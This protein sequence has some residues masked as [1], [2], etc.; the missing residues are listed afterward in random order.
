LLYVRGDVS[1]LSA[2]S[3]ASLARAAQQSMGAQLA[4]R[5]GRDLAKR[6]LVILGGLARGVDAL[7]ATSVGA[8]PLKCLA[9]ASM[10]A[11]PRK[12]RDCSKRPWKKMR[13]SGTSNPAPKNFPVW[14]RIIAGM[15][16]G[17]VIEGKQCNGSLITACLAMEFAREVSD[18]PGKVT[19]EV[20][21]APNLLNKPG[22]KLVQ[23]D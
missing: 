12:T 9:Q 21:F 8:A 18:V 23:R 20:S 5:L 2:P 16:L 17:V 4:E 6:G 10:F 13:S 11:I 19:E 15:P 3:Y 7:S 22:A 14:K 1:V